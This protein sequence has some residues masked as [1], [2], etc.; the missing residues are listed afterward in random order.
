M[1]ETQVRSLVWEVLTLQLWNNYSY[2]PQLLGLC[3]RAWELKLL[4]PWAITA[5]ACLLETV[6]FNKKI[7]TLQ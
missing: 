3:S 2:A 1:Q 4:S 5:E 7:H 6:L